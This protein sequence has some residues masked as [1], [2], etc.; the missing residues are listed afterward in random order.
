MAAIGRGADRREL[1]VKLGAHI[2]IDS[3]EQNAAEALQKQARRTI[4]F[5]KLRLAPRLGLG[6]WR[7]VG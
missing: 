6:S 1:A 5:R 7:S 4:H 2:Y 3:L